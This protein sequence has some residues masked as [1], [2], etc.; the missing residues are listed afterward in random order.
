MF[1]AKE[2]GWSVKN[3]EQNKLDLFYCIVFLI[4]YL[5]LKT[6]LK[7]YRYFWTSFTRKMYTPT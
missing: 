4:S 1:Q 6:L 2:F 3:E 5:S 7:G